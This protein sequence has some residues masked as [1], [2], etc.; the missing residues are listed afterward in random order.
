MFRAI[1]LTKF[2]LI[3]FLLISQVKAEALRTFPGLIPLDSEGQA[4][5]DLVVDNQ[6][7]SVYE[8]ERLRAS[9][10]DISLFLPQESDIWHDQAIVGNSPSDLPVMHI[11][12]GQIPGSLYLAPIMSRTGNF[13]FS[14]RGQEQNSGQTF[15]FMLSKKAHSVLLRSAL[16]RKIGYTIP[17]IQYLSKLQVNFGSTFERENFIK[18]MAEDTF[19]DPKRW[20]Y[21]ENSD[22][23]GL[24]LQDVLSFQ[25]NESIYNLAYGYVPNSVIKGR[26]VLNSLLIP[27]A[28]V[29]FEE[30]VNLMSYEAARIISNSLKIDF[31]DSAEF[32]TS[33][34]DARWI[35]R[36]ILKLTRRDFEEI[37]ASAHLPI[38]VQRLLVEKII[39]RR[40]SMIKLLKL[41]AAVLSINPDVNFGTDLKKGKLLRE[42]WDGYGSRFSYGDP[43]S[44]FSGGEILRYLKAVGISN[45]IGNL[46]GGFNSYVVPSTDVQQGIVDHQVAVAEKA[47]MDY[48]KTGVF[49]EVPFG[50]FAIP[51]FGADLIASRDI[52]A[53]SYMGADNTVQLADSF[54][55]S[56][57][58]GVYLGIDGVAAPWIVNGQA[59][60]NLTRR[61]SHLRPIKSMKAALKTPYR[62]MM[63]PFYKKGLAKKLDGLMTAN[64]NQAGNA[65]SDDELSEK[66]ESVMKDFLGQ[67]EV[68]ESLMITDSLTPSVS[69]GAGVGLTSLISAQARIFGQQ[70]IISRLHILRSGEKE[71]QVYRDLGNLS[72]IGMSIGL[73][74][75]IPVMSLSLSGSKGK[76]RTKFYTLNLDAKRNGNAKTLRNVH[77]LRALLLH[78]ETELLDVVQSPYKIEHS[79][80]EKSGAF[81]LFHWKWLNRD[82]TDL[83]T[84]TH[85]QGAQKMFY[86]SSKGKRFGSNY[87]SLF[88]DVAN[89]L[90]N[91]YVS[92]AVNFS[93]PGNGNPG[94]TFM[95]KSKA[96]EVSF[97]G[98][99]LN[100]NSKKKTGRVESPFISLGYI[101]KGWTISKKNAMKIIDEINRDYQFH[102]YPETALQNTKSLQL[103]T[104]SVNLYFYH[105]AVLEMLGQEKNNLLK[106][107]KKHSKFKDIRY[108]G[109]GY[110]PGDPISGSSYRD[111]YS[112]ES[113]I[114]DSV[115]RFIRLKKKFQK[116]LK[117]ERPD[118]QMKYGVKMA[119]QVEKNLYFPGLAQVVGG[120]NN[121]YVHSQVRGFRKGDEAGDTPLISHSIGEF[122][123]R[124]FTGPLLEIK[125][126]MGM[127]DAEFFSYWMV[128]KI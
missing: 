74:A 17:P 28:I 119:D 9:G 59:K 16:L 52:I 69:V 104:I 108:A 20:V 107:Y 35:M 98:E 44:P 127:T 76:A 117:K 21:Q 73:R 24:I 116:W 25:A 55:L 45:L 36:R 15:S 31:A 22:G 13:R 126:Q 102:F 114:R 82:L 124:S 118:R 57:D 2:T 72:T 54:G 81:S 40:N 46:V 14:A 5:T 121:I 42:W 33:Y 111:T 26:R 79:L 3:F 75:F 4:A 7:I 30:S 43:E 99:I 92:N 68:G 94:D 67:L 85:P 101:W 103:Y 106:I 56:L 12:P 109:M 125:N 84:V 93:D 32:S 65:L 29:S 77:A 60:A 8:G 39:G 49:K 6:L 47:F 61:Y 110:F 88:T 38:P 11:T 10:Q 53:G 89:G 100:Y 115:S 90:L 122:G 34:E 58:L 1:H 123:D 78:N 96:R 64:L 87:Q 66:I 97:E 83:I 23:K 18:R 70:V 80:T 27:Y 112:K 63:I 51:T 128:G 113:Q 50:I 62:N 71:I 105:R 48:L 41:D 19:G 120:E 91:T 95:G 37:V 86:R